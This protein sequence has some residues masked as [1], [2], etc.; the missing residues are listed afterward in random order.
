MSHDCER[1]IYMSA[2]TATVDQ[3]GFRSQL[4]LRNQCL[5]GKTRHPH[6]LRLIIEN[7]PAGAESII[8]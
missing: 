3:T 2:G 5:A 7:S 6:R 4:R 8:G 1:Q